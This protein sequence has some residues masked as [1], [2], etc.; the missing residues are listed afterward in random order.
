MADSRMQQWIG[1]RVSAA[2][3]GGG[4]LLDD[5][6]KFFA[7]QLSKVSLAVRRRGEPGWL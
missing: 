1:G 2:L 3:A 6:G 7:G 5:S 4:G